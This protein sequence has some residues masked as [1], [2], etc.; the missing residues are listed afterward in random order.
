[1]GYRHLIIGHV[2]HKEIDWMF[3]VLVFT[4]E[5][6]VDTQYYKFQVMSLTWHILFVIVENT[7]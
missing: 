5:H 3:M 2:E 1:M 4:N 7:I 6:L